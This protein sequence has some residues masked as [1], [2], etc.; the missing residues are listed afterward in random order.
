V[1]YA[2]CSSQHKDAVQVTLEQIDLI[3]RLVKTYPN[4]LELVK[5]SQGKK[6]QKFPFY[7]SNKNADGL[8]LL[9]GCLFK[10]LTFLRT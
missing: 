1:A 4:Q 10:L 5:T 7:L 9:C 8:L 2:P 3:K 6:S